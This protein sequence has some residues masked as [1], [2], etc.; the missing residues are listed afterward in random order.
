MEI[1]D[2]NYILITFD[3]GDKFSEK[4]FRISL[5]GYKKDIDIINKRN[6]KLINVVDVFNKKILE[7]VKI[8]NINGDLQFLKP[9]KFSIIKRVIQTYK[10]GQ[11]MRYSNKPMGVICLY[12]YLG[13]YSFLKDLIRLM[14]NYFERW[15]NN[16]NLL[17]FG[18]KDFKI[19]IGSEI[20][21]T[22]E[23]EN[24]D[25]FTVIFDFCHEK[26]DPN[27]F[28]RSLLGLPKGKDV[29]ELI[30]N[31][32]IEK[33]NQKYEEKIDKNIEFIVAVDFSIIKDPVILYV[34]DNG[35]KKISN[36]AAGV[37]LIYKYLGP[38]TYIK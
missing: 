28:R 6:K 19:F 22:K 3:F 26:A 37:I 2:E 21:D 24:K 12:K 23:F 15:T 9:I 29:K 27:D 10:I 17:Y 18:I 20:K 16:E 1:K 31:K 34:S 38:L 4:D 32:F 14:K 11:R 13:P 35:E 25:Y 7:N 33:I 8:D 5:T 36:L 30:N